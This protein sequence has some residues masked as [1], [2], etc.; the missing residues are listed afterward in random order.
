MES[1]HTTKGK[2]PGLVEKPCKKVSCNLGLWQTEPLELRVGDLI[3]LSKPKF[4]GKTLEVNYGEFCG[5]YYNSGSTRY[6]LWLGGGREYP[7]KIIG[8]EADTFLLDDYIISIIRRIE[9][10]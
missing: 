3:A 2:L 6:E 1:D 4:F 10:I 8:K 9:N 7:G 5:V